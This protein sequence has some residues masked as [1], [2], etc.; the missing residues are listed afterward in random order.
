MRVLVTGGA[1][2]IG[3]YVCVELGRQ[4][5]TAIV[6]DS[7]HED[8]RDADMLAIY[9]SARLDAVIH[10][11]GRLGT[12]EL[13]DSVEE[14]IDV[15]VKG[16]FNVLELCRATGARFVGITM[17]DCWPNVYQATKHCAKRLASA[18]H[19][20][21][22]V[23]V[24]HVRAFN[25]FG[26]GQKYGPGH[27]QK[28]VPTFASKAWAHEPLPIWGDG[29]QTV[30]LISAAEVARVIVAALDFGGDHVFDAG[31]GIE[32]PV[33]QVADWVNYYTGNPAGLEFL[34]MRAGERPNTRLC[35]SGEGWNE[36]GWQPQF[37]FDDFCATLASY[38]RQVAA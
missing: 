18:W 34:P 13:F 14:A 2:F 38:R 31:S 28:I 5:H 8:V 33:E 6:F 9:K 27:P 21:Y 17:P 16:T 25:V 26:P 15:N 35:A 22:G 3:S 24:S 11:A 1:G 20:S 32:I 37:D 4:R 23:P 10:L 19:E 29:H 36:L 12:A 7:P 30:D